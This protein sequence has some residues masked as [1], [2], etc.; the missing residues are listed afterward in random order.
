MANITYTICPSSV[1]DWQT[2]LD[3]FPVQETILNWVLSSMGSE[4]DP[5]PLGNNLFSVSE[6]A[7]FFM[8]RMMAAMGVPREYIR[9]E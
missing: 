1:S 3:L 6:E 9:N 5:R 7:E 2:A 8:T 4:A